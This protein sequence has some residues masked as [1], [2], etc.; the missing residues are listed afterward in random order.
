MINQIT[1]KQELELNSFI[2]D[3]MSRITDISTRYIQNFTTAKKDRVAGYHKTILE[4]MQDFQVK[5]T[6]DTVKHIKRN[7]NLTPAEA[8]R[9]I[10]E[11]RQTNAK[12]IR[13][14]KYELEGRRDH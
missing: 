6:V 3:S 14:K 11:I 1:R 9:Q 4:K 5:K 2:K 7:K 12:N 8:N 13:E 10:K